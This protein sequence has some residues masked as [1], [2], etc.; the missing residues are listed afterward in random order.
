MPIFTVGCAAVCAKIYEVGNIKKEAAADVPVIVR[1]GVVVD[2]EQTIVG[3]VAIVT[4][5]VEARVRR[6]EVPVIA[7]VR[8]VITGRGC[9]DKR[10]EAAV[11]LDIECGRPA[12]GRNADRRAIAAVAELG[13]IQ[14]DV[15]AV[16][17]VVAA[18]A[19]VQ[20]VIP[21]ALD[22]AV[23]R[24]AVGGPAALI[25]AGVVGH[26]VGVAHCEG[27]AVRTASIADFRL[28]VPVAKFDDIEQPDSKPHGKIALPDGRAE[29]VDAGAGRRAGHVRPGAAGAALIGAVAVV[30]ADIHHIPLAVAVTSVHVGG[31][32][33]VTLHRA[34]GD[35]DGHSPAVLGQLVPKFRDAD[36]RAAGAFALYHARPGLQAVERTAIAACPRYIRHGVGKL[37]CLVGAAPL[38]GAGAV[39]A[40]AVDVDVGKLKGIIPVLA[41]LH[42]ALG[43]LVAQ[44]GRHGPCASDGQIQLDASAL[45]HGAGHGLVSALGGDGAAS[46]GCHGQGVVGQGQSLGAAI[47]SL[48]RLRGRAGAERG[49]N[50]PLSVVGQG[51]RKAAVRSH[52]AHVFLAVRKDDGTARLGMHHH[53]GQHDAAHRR[54]VRRRAGE[55]EGLVGLDFD[56]VDTVAHGFGV[57]G[58]ALDGQGGVGA[59]DS[60]CIV[61]I[62]LRRSFTLRR[63]VF[64]FFRRVC[65]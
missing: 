24:A 3:V 26:R 35:L 37:R 58:S 60:R 10:R 28:T 44:R 27:V 45:R 50:G 29:I 49:G 46:L 34:V 9:G 20:H 54:S 5:D 53:P 21:Q 48:H 23:L 61:R 55:G 38:G 2:V 18:I 36:H 65:G 41:H 62:L 63:S 6:A 33:A 4:T 32:D 43:G 22:V 16:A 31:A 12:I 19:P 7:R 15:Q 14:D 59:Y 56:G 40:R 52:S 11:C 64:T 30:S 57:C 25:G 17:V 1:R 8:C 51:R 39:P 47:L 13:G 42:A